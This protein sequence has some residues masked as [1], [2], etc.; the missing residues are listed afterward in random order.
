MIIP[1]RLTAAVAVAGSLLLTSACGAGATDAPEGSDKEKTIRVGVALAGPRNDNAFYQTYLEGVTKNA[2]AMNLKV[3]VV[4]NLVAPQQITDA[5]TNLA[6]DNDLIIGGGSA[7]VAG[8]NAIA[9]THPD[10]T[11]VMSGV[12]TEG[13]GNLHAY[14]MLQGVPAY[15]AG[16][17]A[18]KVTKTGKVG[19]IGGAQIPPTS[20]SDIDFKAGAH[21]TT[22]G[23]KYSA[24]TVGS[25]SD[26]TKAKQAAA[27]QITDG[28]DV[29]YA[30][31]DAGLPGVLQAIEESGKDV[32][33]FNPTTNRCKESDALIGYDYQ[34]NQQLVTTILQDYTSGRL[35]TGTKKYALED[36]KIQKLTMCPNSAD[37]QAEADA[38][39]AKINAGEIKMPEGG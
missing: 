33:V 9:A 20:Q 19:F 4:D 15:V 17:L 18:A 8:A 27:A 35:P 21:A 32:K 7:L 26:A 22:P 39:T 29:I 3:S 5:L 37:L 1:S 14:M 38:V 24:I 28:V 13:I 23:I 31:V 2:E 11:F 36:P 30:F 16:V 34:N 12:V 25:F 6:A 10:T